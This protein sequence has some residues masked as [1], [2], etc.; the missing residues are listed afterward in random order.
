MFVLSCV[1]L[2][3]NLQNFFIAINKSNIKLFT[4][5]ILSPPNMPHLTPNQKH[6]ILM[7][8]HPNDSNHT[9]RALADEYNIKGGRKV[10]E[11]WYHQWTGTPQSLERKRGSGRHKLLTSK[12]VKDYIQIPIRNKNRAN[13]PIHYPELLPSITEKTGKQISVRTLRRIGHDQ[14]GAK[15]KRTNKRTAVESKYTHI[16]Y[17]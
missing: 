5:L 4:Y 7:L 2:I 6:N 14:L 13:V 8:Y 9:F 15:Q 1:E 3:V 17:I 11:N 16:M 10:I 12:Q